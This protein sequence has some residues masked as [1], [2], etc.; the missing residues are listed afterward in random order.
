MQ[1]PFP[2][3]ER[4]TVDDLQQSFDSLESWKEFLNEGLSVLESENPEW[5]SFIRQQVGLSP[6][7]VTMAALAV[8]IHQMNRDDAKPKIWSGNTPFFR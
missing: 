7:H 8:V 6:L 2:K 1:M 3:I 5:A 4:E